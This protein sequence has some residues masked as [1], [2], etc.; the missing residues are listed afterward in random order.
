MAAFEFLRGCMKVR[1]EIKSR[2]GK[3][4]SSTPNYLES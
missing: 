1:V 2:K 3:K 4:W